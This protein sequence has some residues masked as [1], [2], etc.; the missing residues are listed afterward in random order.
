[1]K[2]TVLISALFL[3]CTSAQ[4]YTLGKPHTLGENLDQAVSPILEQAHKSPDMDLKTFQ[5]SPD[6]NDLNALVNL[7]SIYLSRALKGWL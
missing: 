2:K 5:K 1:M 7:A 4:A 6:K 3:M